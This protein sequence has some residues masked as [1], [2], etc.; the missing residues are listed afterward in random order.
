MS[1]W[2]FKRVLRGCWPLVPTLLQVCHDDTSMKPLLNWHRISSLRSSLL[3]KLPCLG[4]DQLQAGFSFSQKYTVKKFWS[5]F[6]I[7]ELRT[8]SWKTPARRLH[9][10]SPGGKDHAETKWCI[11]SFHCGLISWKKSL[12]KIVLFYFF[13]MSI[14]YFYIEDQ[15]SN[16]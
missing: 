8:L 2:T 13:Q 5:R 14:V 3:E 12:L 4:E 16:M 7:G 9:R 10:L 1:G 11:G 6:V 15:I